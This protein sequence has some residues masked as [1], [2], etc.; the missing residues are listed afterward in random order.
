MSALPIWADNKLARALLTE[1]LANP[2]ETYV[3]SAW[4][5]A[6]A[7]ERFSARTPSGKL[8]CKLRRMHREWFEREQAAL[9]TQYHVRGV[10][11]QDASNAIHR[12]EDADALVRRLLQAGAEAVAA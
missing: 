12:T 2:P 10:W 7:D 6:P 5:C 9:D 8:V 4:G 1:I 3:R 11:N